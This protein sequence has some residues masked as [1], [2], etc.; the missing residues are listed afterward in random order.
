MEEALHAWVHCW[1]SGADLKVIDKVRVTHSR[2]GMQLAPLLST[3]STTTTHTSHSASVPTSPSAQS[4][5]Y[6]TTP[7]PHAHPPSRSWTQEWCSCRAMAWAT[8][9]SRSWAGG[10][11]ALG[12]SR[13]GM[14]RSQPPAH[15]LAA[16]ILGCSCR[17]CLAA[18]AF[19]DFAE[20]ISTSHCA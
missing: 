14:T 8:G 5:P 15:R 19:V 3:P 9:P 6:P 2:A 16:R 20:H 1:D 11:G 17:T 18:T 4:H 7:R 12:A 10:W 13:A